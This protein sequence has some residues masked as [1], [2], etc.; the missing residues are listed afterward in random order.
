M[1][2]Q[3]RLHEPEHDRAFHINCEAAS[4]GAFRAGTDSLTVTVAQQIRRKGVEEMWDSIGIYAD[5]DPD[6]TM[7]VRVLVFNPDWDEPL[8]IACIRSRPQDPSCL[9]PL[10][11]SLDHATLYGDTIVPHWTDR[12]RAT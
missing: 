2:P 5:R 6:G 3:G 11:C 10:G 9:T 8:Q 7:I 4:A 1:K 12:Q